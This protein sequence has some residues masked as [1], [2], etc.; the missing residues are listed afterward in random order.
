M[1]NIEDVMN[2]AWEVH[3]P[4]SLTHKLGD[5]MNLLIVVVILLVALSALAAHRVD[6]WLRSFALL[7][8]EQA[9]KLIIISAFIYCDLRCPVPSSI[10]TCP[11]RA[12][13][14]ARPWSAACWP[15]RS[16][17]L[18]QFV[19]VLFQS[20]LVRNKIYGV[21]GNVLFCWLWAMFL[22]AIVLWGVEN[23]CCA[24]RTCADLPPE[25]SPARYAGRTRDAGPAVTVLLADP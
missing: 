23:S 16:F 14:R 20:M 7:Y 13:A 10:F 24:T 12:C 21:F 9:A 1:S 17:Y 22:G 8:H 6:S 11:T 3:R 18:T 15:A 19:F 5:Y 2:L 4:R 25:A